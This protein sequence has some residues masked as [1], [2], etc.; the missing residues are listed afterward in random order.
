V[1]KGLAVVPIEKECSGGSSLPFHTSSSG[2]R[3]PAKNNLLAMNHSG[4]NFSRNPGFCRE[5]EQEK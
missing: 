4:K 3:L 5:E 1:V 2:D